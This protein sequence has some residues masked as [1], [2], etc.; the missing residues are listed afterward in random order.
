MSAFFPCIIVSLLYLNLFVVNT[1]VPVCVFRFIA[2]FVSSKTFPCV[3]VRLLHL[4][5]F[6][7]DTNVPFLV[8]RFIANLFKTV[9]QNRYL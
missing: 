4:D 1:N 5:L 2:N 7:V 3:V 8:V 9:R 6:V